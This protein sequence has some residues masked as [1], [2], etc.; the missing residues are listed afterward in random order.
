MSV[1]RVDGKLSGAASARV[2]YMH[3]TAEKKLTLLRLVRYC[4]Q[5]TTL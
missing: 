1:P 4:V 5:V 2:L 3:S